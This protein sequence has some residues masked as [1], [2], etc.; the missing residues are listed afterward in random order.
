MYRSDESTLDLGVHGPGDWLGLPELVLGGPCLADAVALEGCRALA[1]D[2]VVLGRWK[3]APGGTDW[4][5][6]EL[7][8]QCYA[9]HARVEVAQPGQRL[10]RWLVSRRDRRPGAIDCTQDELAVAIGTT[11][12]TVNRHLGRLQAEGLLRV[13]RGRVTVLDVEALA[14]WGGE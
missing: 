9:L 12:E 6:A 13:E 3:A 7:A 5:S 4:L 10:A 14:T 8:R 1:F 11:R 2:K